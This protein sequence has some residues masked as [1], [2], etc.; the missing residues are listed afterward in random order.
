MKRILVIVCTI[1][2]YS[3][4]FSQLTYYAAAKAGLSLREQPITSSKVLEK[5]PY[6]E[7]LITHSV[8]TIAPVA[9]LTEGFGGY[10]WKAT[11]NNKTGYVVSNYVLPL[12]P[13]KTGTKTMQDYF[14]QVSAPAGNQLVIKKTD[15]SLN[16]MG[17]STLIKQLYQNGMEWHKTEG[18]EN[19]SY[20][21]ILPDLSIEQCFLLMRL[22]GQFPD[23]IGEKD[24]FPTKKSVIKIDNGDKTIEVE[25]ENY[26]GK[27]GPV[28]KIKIGLAQGAVTEFEI[29]MLDTQA[30]IFWT[31]GV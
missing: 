8:D 7:K 21:Y 31:S 6:G 25:R 23:L 5:I 13:P 18:Y 14:A 15:A 4:A 26:D 24:V 2:F 22:I 12:P 27:P 9:I 17:E 16:E 28:N 29:F 30:I 20:L 3:T 1:F 10:W 19:G 11:Y